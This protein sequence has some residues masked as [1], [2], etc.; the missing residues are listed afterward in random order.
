MAEIFLIDGDNNLTSLTQS[1]YDSEALLQELLADHP[2]LLGGDQI[3]SQVARR[4]LFVAREVGVPDQEG[5][6]GR[7]S[8][9]HL[10][11][12]QD[13]IPTLV[14]VKRASDTRIRR[15]VVGQLLDYAANG[16]KYWPV[17]QL[18][19]LLASRTGDAD[20]ALI[21]A[22]GDETDTAA[23]WTALRT[24]MADGRVRLLFVADKIPDEL[25]A[26]VEFLNRQMD[27][28]EV[29][30]VEIPQFVGQGLRTLAPRVLGVTQ[31][32]QQKKGRIKRVPRPEFQ[33]V[34]EAFDKASVHG[35]ATTGRAAGYRQIRVP[36][37]PTDLHY[38]FL[39]NGT[40]IG[41]E[42]H[43]ESGEHPHV[44]DC[45]QQLSRTLEAEFPETKYSDKWMGGCRLIT[46]VPVEDA[47]TA[48]ETMNRLIESTRDVIQERLDGALE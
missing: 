5:A 22:F 27:H 9:D 31:E 33:A 28:T 4:W 26:V 37:W 34:V 23:Y 15:E 40:S 12:D 18:Q 30:A 39:D 38:E 21:E 24:N 35:I 13:A 10:F 45:I 20:A 17:E 48:V 42:I 41:V 2:Q 25:L 29:L 1:D 32:S 6:G 3:G 47:Q 16:L 8:L 36:G 43:L 7:W 46:A 44:P 11:L 14:E 19:S